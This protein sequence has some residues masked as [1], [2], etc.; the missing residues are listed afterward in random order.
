MKYTLE[1]SVN[2]MFRLLN[3]CDTALAEEKQ[4][5]DKVKGLNGVDPH[6]KANGISI[7]ETRIAE[8]NAIKEKIKHCKLMP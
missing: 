4:R 6:H 1:L 7:V 5:L 2:E 8:I 3:M